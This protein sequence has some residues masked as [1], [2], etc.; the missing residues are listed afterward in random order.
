[1][2]IVIAGP[3]GVGKGTVLRELLERDPLLWLSRSWTTRQR[4]E[5]ESPEA[6][7]FASRDEFESKIADGGFVEHV[8]FLDYLQGSPIPEPPPGCDAVFEID[9]HG[10]RQLIDRFDDVRFIFIDA[11]TRAEQ[12]ARLRGRGES[13]ERVAQR[14][15]KAEEEFEVALGLGAALVVNDRLDEAVDQILELIETWRTG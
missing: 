7:V 8:E 10:A 4:R 1:M 5:N 12:E 9:V 11:P 2:I 13:P 6:Y 14:L 15:I 3:G